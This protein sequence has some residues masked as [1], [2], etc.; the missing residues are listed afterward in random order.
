MPAGLNKP[1]TIVHIILYALPNRATL[2]PTS[3]PTPSSETCFLRGEDTTAIP[4]FNIPEDGHGIAVDTRR[5]LIYVSFDD[6]VIR[7]VNITDRS[8]MILVGSKE[9]PGDSDGSYSVARFNRPWG[10]EYD[11]RNDL[12]YVADSVNGKI[13]V[14]DPENRQVHTLASNS[15]WVPTDVTLGTEQRLFVPDWKNDVVATVNTSSGRISILAGSGAKGHTDGPATSAKFSYPQFSAVLGECLFVSNDPSAVDAY[16]RR[17][18][19]DS[20][21]VSTLIGP[22]QITQPI[23]GPLSSAQM[24]LVTGLAIDDR[25]SVLYLSLVGMKSYQPVFSYL[26]LRLRKCT[27][28]ICKVT[29]CI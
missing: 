1:L 24:S 20:G 23:D 17:I 4:F 25:C 7:S 5:N 9:E 29:L 16:V 21:N 12:L 26:R 13:R 3:S 19:V 15:S 11:E 28:W 8:R 22:G 14:I 10:L 6:H 27:L 2:S 18:N